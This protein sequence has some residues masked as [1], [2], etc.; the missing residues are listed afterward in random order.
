MTRFII[1]LTAVAVLLCAGQ[2]ARA[3][4]ISIFNTQTQQTQIDSWIANLGGTQTVIEDFES[5]NT[6]WYESLATN[7]GVFETTANTLPG[8]GSSSYRQKNPHAADK[9]TP[10]FE[11]RDY[12]ANGRFNTTPAPGSHYL[13][14]AD[15]T[16]IKL[17]L[18]VDLTN[19]FFY[20][21]DPSD[22]GA[23]TKTETV[24]GAFSEFANIDYSSSNN[25][26]IWFVGISADD[27]IDSI[28][29]TTN[30]RNGTGYYTNDGFGLDDFTTVAAV[31]EPGTLL[32]VGGGLVGVCLIRRRMHC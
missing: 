24:S 9:S 23:K 20:L 30:G 29:W 32:L 26:K 21:S 11:L 27:L 5:L 6:G 12:D 3:L 17:T 10:Y 8:T 19:L 18:G 22:V 25:K 14:S 1:T 28:T 15:I 31:P 2:P 7:V 4:Q 13:D 16:E